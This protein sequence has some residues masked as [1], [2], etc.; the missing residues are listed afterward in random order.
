MI[1]PHTLATAVMIKHDV[2]SGMFN[3]SFSIPA[4]FL[5]LIPT[6]PLPSPLR[7]LSQ[8]AS[9]VCIFTHK[10]KVNYYLQTLNF[11]CAFVYL[12]L[13]K[14]QTCNEYYI[15]SILHTVVPGPYLSVYCKETSQAFLF[16][17]PRDRKEQ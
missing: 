17:L 15:F 2:S 7:S 6:S 13:T 12:T 4:L 1:L 5:F 9:K 3:I 16:I 10:L 8:A 14:I 11:Q